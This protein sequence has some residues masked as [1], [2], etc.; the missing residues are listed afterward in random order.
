MY[1]LTVSPKKKM[2]L[3]TYS[4]F[5]CFSKRIWFLH[6]SF[7][8][9]SWFHTHRCKGL[10][11]TC[12]E[13]KALIPR[14]LPHCSFEFKNSKTGDIYFGFCHVCR[15]FVLWMHRSGILT[16]S[17]RISDFLHYYTILYTFLIFWQLFDYKSIH[18][19]C[20]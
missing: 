9:Q 2:Q 17:I 7:W 19:T 16:F 10:S 13:V 14:W 12:S 18:S 8:K 11:W 3:F 20:K 1:L 6:K 15:D 4:F 5:I